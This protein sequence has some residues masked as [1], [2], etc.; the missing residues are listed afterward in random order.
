MSDDTITVYNDK[1]QEYAQMS[2]KL[3]ELPEMEALAALLP[4]GARLLDLGCG[5]GQYSA[6]FAAHGFE[7]DALDASGEMVA[8]AA[9][10]PGVTARQ[11]RFEDIPTAPTYDAIWANFSLLH[12]PRAALPAQLRRMKQALHPSGILHLG[13][14][15]GS[16]EATDQLGRFYAYWSEDELEALLLEYG[17]TITAR[18]L[19]QGKGLAGDMDHYILIRAHG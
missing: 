14:K 15:L 19:G 1:A 2:A 16:G 11:G 6:W 10:Q 18:R 13:M 9:A 8:L 4:A 12:L 3:H 5:P 7:V 17:F